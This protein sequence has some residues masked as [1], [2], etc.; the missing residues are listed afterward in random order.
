MSSDTDAAA[1][2][3]ALFD[4]LYTSGYCEVT[5]SVLFI[6][7]TFITFDRE[8]A[9]FWTAKPIGGASLLFFANRW[10][11]MTLYIMAPIGF[12]SFTSDKSCSLFVIATQVMEVL[13]FVPGAA[14]SALRTYVLS[15]SKPLGLLIAALSLAPV[16]AN[17]LSGTTSP[18]FGCLR[19]SKNTATLDLR[20]NS[21]IF[22]AY[23]GTDPVQG[24]GWLAPLRG[25]AAL[26]AMRQSK[27]LSLQDILFRGDIIAYGL[28]HRLSKL[29][30][31]ILFVLNVLHLVFSATSVASD[32]GSA[33]FVTKFMAPITAILISCFLLELQQANRMVVKLDAD[34]PMHSSR[35]VWDSTPSFISSLG[36]FVNPAGSARSD[37]DNAIEMQVHSP[38]G[39]PGEEAEVLVEVPEAALSSSSTA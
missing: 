14:F 3:A 35:N 22:I 34:D 18:S 23:T 4:I 33:S 26:T 20:S 39:A 7:D 8:V 12:A 1:A 25:W 21:F 13:Q 31:S 17:L 19:T 27:R 6:Y 32:D 30:I 10:I 5:A 15:R 38:S 16:G 29:G 2:T 9:Y 37:D 28:P 36:G 11:S 24:V